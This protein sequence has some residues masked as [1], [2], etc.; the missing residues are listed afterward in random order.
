M[1]T[2]ELERPPA[3]T[4][5]RAPAPRKT[6]YKKIYA[7][8]AW[9][10]LMV[11]LFILLVRATGTL[12][13]FNPEIDWL[14]TPALR[15]EPT[16]GA[17]S[18][19]GILDEV[20]RNNPDYVLKSID[21]QHGKRWAHVVRVQRA[22]AVPADGEVFVDPYTG[23]VQGERFGLAPGEVIKR[24]HTNLW[25][26]FAGGKWGLIGRMLVGLLGFTLVVL[27]ITGFIIYRS[28]FRGLFRIR[29]RHGRRTFFSDFH[30]VLGIWT[31]GFNLIMGS[32]ATV[33]AIKDSSHFFG[34]GK[35]ERGGA[36][37]MAKPKTPEAAGFT[38]G[39]D[40]AIASAEH[41]VPGMAVQRVSIPQN[42]NE[43]AK[44]FGSVSEAMVPQQKVS[45][46]VKAGDGSV[47]KISDGRH[48]SAGEKFINVL[49]P[50]HFAE[51]TE[52]Y[53]V[54][55]E[56]GL[57]ILWVLLGLSP[58]LLSLSGAQMYFIRKRARLTEV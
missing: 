44:V 37:K 50:L 56:Y 26:N 19:D 53:G 30:K 10:G 39:L 34:E 22:G 40:K 54:F 28:K 6:L 11:A 21:L 24:F 57:K 18:L 38:S 35:G 55:A 16:V 17:A 12:T 31:I 41:A 45:L 36:G 1:P 49:K 27:S 51:L 48:S 29:L 52:G 5:A 15:V 43:A 33:F 13:A 14:L 42:A 47:G 46:E 2:L 58:G 25:L 8:H 3:E 20:S 7:I 23:K 32:T 9:V 4:I